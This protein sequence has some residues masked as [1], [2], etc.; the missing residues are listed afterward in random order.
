M[1]LFLLCTLLLAVFVG[2]EDDPLLEPLGGDTGGGG[3]YGRLAL[4]PKAEADSVRLG[5]AQPDAAPLA[6]A[7][8]RQF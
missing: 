1:R 7:N 4:T 8:P 3:S 5:A 2:C 6:P